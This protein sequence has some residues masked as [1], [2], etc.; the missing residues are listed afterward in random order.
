M[1]HVTVWSFLSYS[2]FFLLPALSH[3]T[4][5]KR[6]Q[7]LG[8]CGLHTERRM[9]QKFDKPFLP[10]EISAGFDSLMFRCTVNI[11]CLTLFIIN[12]YSS[13]RVD[14]TDGRTGRE[15]RRMWR[16][17][18]SRRKVL[19]FCQT[20]YWQRERT[21]NWSLLILILE[22][23]QRDRVGVRRDMALI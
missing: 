4:E 15:R 12:F 21:F 3:S 18:N 16:I 14:G 6:S 5:L 19:R 8:V 11:H 17:G 20:P 13:T 2:S 10:F 1:W 9:E 22:T 23:L 7:P